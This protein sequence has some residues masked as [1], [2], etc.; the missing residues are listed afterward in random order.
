MVRYLLVYLSLSKALV[1]RNVVLAFFNNYNKAL[2]N[3]Q[4]ITHP[5]CW[6]PGKPHT[7]TDILFNPLIQ[8][9]K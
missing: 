9:N 5:P 6:L 1:A 3:Q 2:G 8:N 4:Q 7:M